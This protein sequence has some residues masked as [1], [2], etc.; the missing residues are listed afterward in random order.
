MNQTGHQTGLSPEGNAFT[1][2]HY[3]YVEMEER[4]DE[5]GTSSAAVVER[6]ACSPNRKELGAGFGVLLPC[7]RT[8]DVRCVSCKWCKET[9]RYL[10]AIA[11]A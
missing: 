11:R 4:I 9:P 7:Y 3:A 10:S 8:D 5:A 6:I 2:V 1:V